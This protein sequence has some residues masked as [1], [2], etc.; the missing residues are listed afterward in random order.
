MHDGSGVVKLA[1]VV[2]RGEES[3]Q[4]P[5]VEELVAILNNLNK[6]QDL[7]VRSVDR[8]MDNLSNI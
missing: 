7:A 4:A 5:L 2:W 3:D 8:T 1:A 6:I